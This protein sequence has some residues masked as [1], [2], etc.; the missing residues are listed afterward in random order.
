M[1]SPSLFKQAYDRAYDKLYS[2]KETKIMTLAE[3]SSK[4]AASAAKINQEIARDFDGDTV[5]VTYPE[6]VI[7][8][9]AISD[10]AISDGAISEQADKDDIVT[11]D[12]QLADILENDVI[13]TEAT[14][15]VY[16]INQEFDKMFQQEEPVEKVEQPLLI[17]VPD[18][19][20]SSHGDVVQKVRDLVQ[21]LNSN[22]ADLINYKK[23]NYSQRLVIQDL[24]NEVSSLQ[25]MLKETR[26]DNERL[27]GDNQRMTADLETINSIISFEY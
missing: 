1:S 16:D 5:T 24:N 22:A 3:W 18:N 14:S 12:G 21:Q 26:K 8:D 2:K 19:A 23:E 10:G 6:Q 11:P 9:E 17:G 7:F 27:Q 20:Q 25:S 4:L 15:N 13:K